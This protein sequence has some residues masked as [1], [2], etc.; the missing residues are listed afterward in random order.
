MT[1]S[2]G[3]RERDGEHQTESRLILRE[4]PLFLRRARSRRHSFYLSMTARVSLR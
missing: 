4:R 1:E 3:E 2:D